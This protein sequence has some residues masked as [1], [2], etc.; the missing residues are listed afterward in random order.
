MKK[1]LQCLTV[2]ML[3]VFA[4]AAAACVPY[5]PYYTVD[6]AYNAEQGTLTL[7]PAEEDGKYAEG[8]ELTVTVTPKSGYELDH[9]SVTG[10]TNAAPDAD[11]KYTFTVTE[12]TT[13]TATFRE[14]TPPVT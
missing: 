2:L 3:A 5:P 4:A 13:V 6:L 14:E 11:G 7:S 1:L 10:I 8:T 12:D 9:F